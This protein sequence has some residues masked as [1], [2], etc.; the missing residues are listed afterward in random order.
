MKLLVSGQKTVEYYNNTYE[1]STTLSEKDFLN[2]S[3]NKNNL[4]IKL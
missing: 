1:I 4:A 2:L 3:N